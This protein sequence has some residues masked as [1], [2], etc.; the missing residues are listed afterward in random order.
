MA[1]SLNRPGVE[2][3][4]P[5]FTFWV[6]MSVCRLVTAAVLFSSQGQYR[7]HNPSWKPILT[8]AL[9][10][11]AARHELVWDMFSP[12]VCLLKTARH[13]GVF[14]VEN[15]HPCTGD[16]QGCLCQHV[17][18]CNCRCHVINGLKLDISA[19]HEPPVKAQALNS[20]CQQVV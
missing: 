12:V 20:A 6:V 9:G 18:H 5:F 7:R 13:L 14:P 4:A 10:P 1:L 16:L 8:Q 2:Y 17:Q 15:S 11:V 3:A 19:Q